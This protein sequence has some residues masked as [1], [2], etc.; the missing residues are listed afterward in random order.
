MSN[1]TKL[2]FARADS[3]P[4]RLGDMATYNTIEK[5][6]TEVRK[7][8][9]EGEIAPL[10]KAAAKR[11]VELQQELEEDNMLLGIPNLTNNHAIVKLIGFRSETN[12]YATHHYSHFSLPQ[13]H[14]KYDNG[15]C[16][17][18]W[19]EVVTSDVS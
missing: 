19:V 9:A 13:S 3:I 14:K 11:K 16:C 18:G 10:K 7:A 6:N 8:I 5:H 15:R 4:F 17:G 1:L 12:H 2:T